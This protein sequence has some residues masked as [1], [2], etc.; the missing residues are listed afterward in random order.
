MAYV[1]SGGARLAT[2]ESAGAVGRVIAGGGWCR[3]GF[4]FHFLDSSVVYLFGHTLCCRTNLY[5]AILDVPTTITV[6]CRN[7]NRLWLYQ[8]S[9]IISPSPICLRPG[10]EI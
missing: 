2:A 3:G 10:P 9:R 4:D 7:F 5:L 1:V 6:L 8:P